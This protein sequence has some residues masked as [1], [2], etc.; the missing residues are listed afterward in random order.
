MR[1]ASVSL[2]EKSSSCVRVG[3]LSVP[4]QIRGFLE[5]GVIRQFVNIDAAIREHSGIAVDPA[6]P[7]IRG[8]NP[9]KTL[10][11]CCRRHVLLSLS[12]RQQTWSID[13]DAAEPFC[14]ASGTQIPAAR[15]RS[16]RREF[17]S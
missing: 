3:E 14:D 17:Y 5:G 15:R 13:R 4:Q 12:I 6:D 16:H 2:R 8:Y 7:R 1:R 10:H 11:H 9:F